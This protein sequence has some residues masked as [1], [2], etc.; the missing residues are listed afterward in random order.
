[1]KH[2]LKQITAYKINS[3]LLDFHPLWS[4]KDDLLYFDSMLYIPYVESLQLEI[5]KKHHDEPL[6][7]HLTTEKIYVLIHTKYYWLNMWKQIQKYCNFCL[8]CQRVQIICKRQLKLLQLIFILKELWEVLTLNFITGLSESHAYE[9]VYDAILMVMCK[10]SKMSHYISVRKDWTAG[11]LVKAFAR[12]IIRLHE[13][14]QALISDCESVF[15]SRLW[16]NLIFTLKIEHWLS[17]A[18]H[19]QTDEQTEQQ[20]STLK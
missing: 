1:M 2:M 17:T 4:Q 12:E 19:S 15:I 16:I 11:Q 20:N 10:F 9:G 7:G 8:I 5:I 6:A 3:E 18:F 13:V 14:S